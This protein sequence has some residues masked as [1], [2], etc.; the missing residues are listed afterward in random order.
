LAGIRYISERIL[1]SICKTGEIEAQRLFSP[2]LYKE[3]WVVHAVQGRRARFPV[4]K[5]MGLVTREDATR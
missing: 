3:L 4:A 1:D 5:I 2:Y